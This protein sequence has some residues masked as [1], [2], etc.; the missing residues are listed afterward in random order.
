[1]KRLTLLLCLAIAVFGVSAYGQEAARKVTIGMAIHGTDNEYWNQEAEGGKLFAASLPVGA[2]DVQVLT[3]NGDDAKQVNGIKALIAAKGKDVIFY[4]DPSN[5][6][7]TAVIAE[8]CEEAQ[9]YWVSV[10]HLAKGLDPTKYKYYVAHSSVDGVTQGYQIANAMFKTFK[11]PGKGRILALQGMLGNDSAV[12][13]Y[14]GLQKA[15]EENPG[16]E[17]VDTQV[18]D[19]SPQKALTITETWLAKY[20]DIDGIWCANDGMALGVIQALKAKKLNGAIKTV[21]VDGVSEAIRAI[22][23]GDMVA[24]VAN[25]GYLQGGYM[26]AYAYAAYTGKID[27]MKLPVEK[28]LFMTKAH[29]VDK[30][31]VE[32]YKKEFMSGKPSYDFTDLDYPIAG[33]YKLKE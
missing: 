15:L 5:A 7:N 11:T 14:V 30:N 19:W 31:N 25:N 23:N 22:E 32:E 10:W 1:M 9:V 29:F 2:A 24:T 21:G 3:C 27:P 20:S 17:L 26:V 13:R 4:V 12:E 8:L 33:P 28:R 18:A 16:I 6:P